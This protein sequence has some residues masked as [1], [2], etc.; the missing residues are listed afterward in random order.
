MKRLGLTALSVLV[1]IGLFACGHEEADTYDALG[2]A[3]VSDSKHL[4][5]LMEEDSGSSFF[6]RFFFGN[7]MEEGAT[8]DQ[9]FVSE[10]GSHSETN[11]QVEGIDESDIVKTDG[12][13]IYYLRHNALTVIEIGEDASMEVALDRVYD[14]AMEGYYTELYLNDDYLVVLGMFYESEKDRD[15]KE[16]SNDAFM[17]DWYYFPYYRTMSTVEI[18][19]KETLEPVSDFKVS[20]ELNSSRLFEDTLYL[21]STH[22]VDYDTDDKRPY[23]FEGDERTD[24]SYEDIAYLPDM[25]REAFTVIS[26]ITLDDQP[27]LTY[28]IFLGVGAF[29]TLYMSENGIYLASN[30][31]RPTPSEDDSD[32][33][34]GESSGT[35][36]RVLFYGFD[37]EG[38]IEYRGYG[39]YKGRLINQFAMDEHERILRMVTTD[40]WGEAT[41]NRLYTFEQDTD[42]EGKPYLRRL[43]LLDE[44]IG[45][46]RE[47]VRSVRFSETTL[48]VVTFEQTDPF[49]VIDIEDPE[50]PRIEGELEMP[51][52]STYQHPWKDDT[53]IGIGYETDDDGATIGLKFSLYDIVDA[54]DPVEIGESLVLLN[55]EGWQY[56]EAL[57]NHKAILI[58]EPNGFIGLAIGS[59]TWSS[60]YRHEGEYLILSIDAESENPVEIA[61][62]ISHDERFDDEADA[63]YY[64]YAVNRAVTIDDQLY[65]LSPGAITRHAISG[66]FETLEEIDFNQE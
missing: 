29:G 21:I 33:A 64:G 32:T 26:A 31:Y 57:H 58:S 34:V 54:T 45:K 9:D 48:T 38:T 40:G 15:M 65:V 61:A 5:D 44:G 7:T 8:D 51:G 14:D 62:T 4:D 49:Y 10:E 28:D 13:R 25:P 1:L 22:R 27:E 60:G 20:G 55:G 36:G 47:S 12:E 2:L 63:W 43:A 42:E 6:D 53:V 16:P 66:D 3:R 39:D 41:I 35:H 30:Y 56:S 59:T 11:V 23:F 17:A 19:D 37:D 50:N 24:P 52:F 18:F 46:P